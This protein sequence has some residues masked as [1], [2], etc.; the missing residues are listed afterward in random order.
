MESIGDLFGRLRTVLPKGRVLDERAELIQFFA[1][2]LDRTP[3][4][5]GVRLAH[6]SLSELYALKSS[7][8]DR[9]TRNGKTTADK[10][11]WWVTKTTKV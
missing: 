10:Y 7:Y 3:Q 1:T 5:I 6:Y 4:R 2:K 8:N 9:L 11:W